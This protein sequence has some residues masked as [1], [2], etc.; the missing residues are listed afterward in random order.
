MSYTG[1]LLQIDSFMDIKLLS[2]VAMPKTKLLFDQLR[3]ELQC[4]RQAAL[5][6]NNKQNLVCGLAVKN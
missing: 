2:Q 5:L 3:C 6:L 4:R 1:D